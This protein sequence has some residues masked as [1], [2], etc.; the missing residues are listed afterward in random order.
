MDRASIDPKCN[1]GFIRIAAALAAIDQGIL[2]EV[3]LDK[4]R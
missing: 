3:V 4:G 1:G 2:I